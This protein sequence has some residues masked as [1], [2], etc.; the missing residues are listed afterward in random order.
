VVP[1]AYCSSSHA[2]CSNCACRAACA[3][4]WVSRDRSSAART[5]SAAGAR[6][7]GCQHGA[8]AAVLDGARRTASSSICCRRCFSARNAV[9]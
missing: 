3:A 5:C 8:S 4:S 2:N 7:A 9:S 6:S 1:A